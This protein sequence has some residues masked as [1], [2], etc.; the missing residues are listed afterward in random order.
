MFTNINVDTQA[1]GSVSSA[2]VFIAGVAISSSPDD[3]SSKAFAPTQFVL[4]LVR[5]VQVGPQEK[6]VFVPETD[7]VVIGGKRF[8]LS[9]IELDTLT[10]D[11]TQRPYPPNFWPSMRYWQ[12]ANRHNPYVDVRYEGETETDR[13]AKAQA[14]IQSIAQTLQQA[15]SRSKCTWIPKGWSSGQSSAFRLTR[16]ANPS[17]AHGSRLSPA[18]SLDCLLR[19]FL[20]QLLLARA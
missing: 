7:S 9:I 12:F 10:E 18:A 19:R 20:P 2:Y 13:I 15:Q 1:V 3:L 6:F 4:G 16:S 14:D 17:T 8:M 11:P 5:Q